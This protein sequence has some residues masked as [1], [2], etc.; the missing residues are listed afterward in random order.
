[1]MQSIM[2]TGQYR[3]KHKKCPWLSEL[4]SCRSKMYRHLQKEKNATKL[5]STKKHFRD[6]FTF[7]G[8]MALIMIVNK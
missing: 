2:F 3:P 5:F 8:N 1:M 4:R 6:C 7:S